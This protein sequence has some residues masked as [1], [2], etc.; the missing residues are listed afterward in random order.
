MNNATLDP[1]L[2][3]VFPYVAL[4]VFF[5]M[6]IY[7]Y[8]AREFTYS[9]L[10]SQLLEN[11]HHFYG[12]VPFHY[13]ILAVLFGHVVAFAL[14]RQLL[15]FNGVPARLYV[16]EISTFVCALLALFGLVNL[17]VR[18]AAFPA[19]RKVTILSDW[20]LFGLLLYQIVTGISIAI[21][22]PWG[23]SWFAS[24]LTPYLWSLARLS[25][26]LSL[27]A[28][29]PLLVK[30]HIVGAFAIIAYFPF[31]RMVHVL[32]VP[33]PYLWRRPQV[34]RWYGPRVGV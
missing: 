29:M 16:L 1:F 17:I 3:A 27:V 34:V 5:L 2:F 20:A 25:P 9:S 13:G 6:T 22:H 31:S 32:V 11:Q 10:S 21:F 15:W 28:S 19:L 26:E 4:V 24:L 23:S 7:R 18:R 8:R 12:M 14:P 33:N 30:A